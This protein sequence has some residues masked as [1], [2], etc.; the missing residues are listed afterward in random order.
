[1][2]NSWPALYVINSVPWPR[3]WRSCRAAKSES[4]ETSL[5]NRFILETGDSSGHSQ[6]SYFNC[7]SDLHSCSWTKLTCWDFNFYTRGPI[8]TMSRYFK[9]V[10][11]NVR[12]FRSQSLSRWPRHLTA[13][14]SLACYNIKIHFIF[15]LLRIYKPTVWQ[16]NKNKI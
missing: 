1:M 11:D 6:V 14:P 7:D 13:G 4:R 9:Y 8:V 12:K 5:G 15:S 16:K 3:H 2:F 10:S